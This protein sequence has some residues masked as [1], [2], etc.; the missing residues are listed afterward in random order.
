MPREIEHELETCW[1][2]VTSVAKQL[3]VDGRVGHDAVLDSL[4]MDGDVR[5][6]RMVRAAIRCGD[7]PGSFAVHL[8]YN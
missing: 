5:H 3:F 2:S 6:D 4:G 8:P 1:S 7:A